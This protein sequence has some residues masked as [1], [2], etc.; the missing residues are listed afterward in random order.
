VNVW[1]IEVTDQASEWLLSLNQEDRAA[2]AGSFDL[3]EQL[4]PNLADPQWIR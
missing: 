2:I 3:L 4:G 1:D